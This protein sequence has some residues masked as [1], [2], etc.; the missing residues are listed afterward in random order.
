[1][2]APRPRRLRLGLPAAAWLAGACACANAAAAQDVP[3][4]ERAQNDAPGTARQSAAQPALEVP[5]QHCDR[6]P[7]VTVRIGKEEKSFLVDTA[8][9][10]LL[11]LK[12]FPLDAQGRDKAVAIASWTGTSAATAREISIPELA[13]GGHVLRSLKISAVDLSAIARACG[14]RIDGI[15]GVDLLERMGITIDLKERVAR[16]GTAPADPAELS[17]ISEMEAAMHGC[18]EAFNSGDTTALGACFDRDFVLDTPSGEFRGREKALE[19][20][21]GRFPGADSN[22]HFSMQVHDQHAIAGVVW[23]A[24]DYSLDSPQLHLAGR[25]MMLCH[26]Q[27]DRWTILSMHETHDAKPGGTAAP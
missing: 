17:L 21:S 3:P 13:L 26:K 20:L 22:M 4:P 15:L 14:G 19:Y 25:G 23:T 24:Y 12:S 2:N 5:L 27:Q 10:S 16:F 11:N 1:M 18:S 8:A 9:T 6:L 7:V